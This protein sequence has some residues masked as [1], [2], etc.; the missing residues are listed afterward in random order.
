MYSCLR[1]CACSRVSEKSP[2]NFAPLKSGSS[3]EA[4][5]DDPVGQRVSEVKIPGDRHGVLSTHKSASVS[6]S[7]TM[8]SGARGRSHARSARHRGRPALSLCCGRYPGGNGRARAALVS[9][10]S[11]KYWTFSI[12][13]AVSDSG[14]IGSPNVTSTRWRR[15][16]S[17]PA[18]ALWPE[19][20]RWH[21][22]GGA[23]D[24]DRHDREVVMGREHRS[25]TAHA[26]ESVAARA[27][28]L[29]EQQ[30][31]PAVVKQRR[32]G[33]SRPWSCRRPCAR[34]GRC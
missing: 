14:G 16:N 7:A 15:E 3:P 13:A 31:V 12:N 34:P 30:Q 22:L 24:P 11:K 6:H 10:L 25:A 28:P 23:G 9:P 17:R 32:R 5:P 8:P 21:R 29:G 1:R 26:P 33:G 20:A 2:S 4:E 19:R 27:R 18:Q